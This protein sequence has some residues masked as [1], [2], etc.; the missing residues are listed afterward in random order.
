M[1]TSI[2]NDF[3]DVLQLNVTVAK[4]MEENGLFD[5]C[6]S[7]IRRNVN[8]SQAALETNETLASRFFL[9]LHQK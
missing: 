1:L 3:P 2:I 8:T 6:V 7:C 9:L 5:N 4:R